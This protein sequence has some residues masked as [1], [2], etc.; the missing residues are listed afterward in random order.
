M[1]AKTP[2]GM[3]RRKVETRPS[4]TAGL[5][6]SMLIAQTRITQPAPIR[7]G[8]PTSTAPASNVQVSP[9]NH[10]AWTR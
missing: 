5:I 1:I 10:S 3:R 8:S 4:H 7:C 9:G 2:I 6:P